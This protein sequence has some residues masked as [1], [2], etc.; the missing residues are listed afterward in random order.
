MDDAPSAPPG[1]YPAGEGERYWDGR[2]WTPHVRPPMAPPVA[3]RDA[4]GLPHQ[5]SGAS[6]PPPGS[7]PAPVNAPVYITQVAPKSPAL[8]AL[9]S[10]FLP[11]LGSMINGDVAKGIGI[12]VGYFISW[13][14]V[15][16]LVGI[17]GVF[18]FWVWGMVDA[19]EGARR[20]NARHGI[21]S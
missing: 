13:V 12:L 8:S 1:W 7:G 4:H 6:W 17:V 9:A 3:A 15:I 11:G 21:L 14:L 10:F 2:A 18:G 20:W 16:V 19:A 5:V